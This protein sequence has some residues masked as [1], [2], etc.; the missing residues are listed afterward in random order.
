[1]LVSQ[2]NI[3]RK[4]AIESFIKYFINNPI[5]KWFKIWLSTSRSIKSL[6]AWRRLSKTEQHTKYLINKYD[7]RLKYL[8][9]QRNLYNV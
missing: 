1:M 5:K 6:S 3:T 8:K 9:D 2:E 7:K 4:L